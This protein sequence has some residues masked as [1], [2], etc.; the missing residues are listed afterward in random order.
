V[1]ETNAC[2]NVDA[3]IRERERER[4]KRERERERETETERLD[5]VWT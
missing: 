1:H 2:V 4:E 3:V 5:A